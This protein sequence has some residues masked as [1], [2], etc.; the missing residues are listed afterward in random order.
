MI[1]TAKEVLAKYKKALRVYLKRSAELKKT[2][3]HDDFMSYGKEDYQYL[4]SADQELTTMVKV[5]SLTKK[6]DNT[7]TEEIK[8]KL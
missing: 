3:G 8:A 7:I 4:I 6:E 5:L 2:Y 1:K